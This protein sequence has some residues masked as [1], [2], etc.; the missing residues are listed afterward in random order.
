MNM[1]MNGLWKFSVAKKWQKKQ[2]NLK[3]INLLEKLEFFTS[4]SVIFISFILSKICFYFFGVIQKN[5]L[6][7]GQTFCC[8]RRRQ[9]E[10]FLTN[11]FFAAS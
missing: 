8:C 4:Y 6:F 9:F 1:L 5:Q 11:E 7:F 2:P 10:L 3:D